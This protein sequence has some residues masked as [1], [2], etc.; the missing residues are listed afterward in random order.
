VLT[1]VW[2]FVGYFTLFDLGLGRALTKLAAERL[3]A[4]DEH[5]ISA[6]A[7]TAFAMALALGAGGC[8]IGLVLSEYV[9]LRV[10]N[11]PSELQVETLN[12]VYLLSIAIP[13]VVASTALRGLLEAHQ[14]FRAITAVRI[15]VGILTYAGPLLVLPFSQS[16]FWMV[17]VLLTGRIVAALVYIT[18]A[19]QTVPA[20]KQHARLDV[21]LAKSLLTFGGWLTVSNIIGPFLLCADRFF[22]AALL[23]ATD[24]AYYATPYEVVTKLLIIPA[25]VVGVVFPAFSQSYSTGKHQAWNLYRRTAMSVVLVLL[26]I[27][28]LILI[29]AESALA[30]WLNSEFAIHSAAVAQIL[31]V[32]VLIN[33]VGLVAQSFVQSSG[34]PDWSAKLHML[35][36]PIYLVY[37]YIFILAWG[38]LGAALAWLLRVTISMFTLTILAHVAWKHKS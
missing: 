18:L 14:R 17:A 25:A 3:G 11:V 5:Q 9:V 4:S 16:L 35:E 28:L 20:L 6:L 36:L 31:V 22:I 23:S 38:I 2:G 30:H 29:F 24:V 37:L 26:P 12:S 7:T 15:P 33:A 8:F 13:V 19:F 32:G 21:R 27:V 34:H 10:I 1:L